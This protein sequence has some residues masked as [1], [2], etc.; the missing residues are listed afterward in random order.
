MPPLQRSFIFS[1]DSI[2][3]FKFLHGFEGTDVLQTVFLNV[4]FMILQAQGNVPPVN[5]ALRRRWKGL[6]Y[7]AILRVIYKISS[8][9]D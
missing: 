6:E 2:K 8:G 7:Q 5:F 3:I 4:L 9:T 1:K